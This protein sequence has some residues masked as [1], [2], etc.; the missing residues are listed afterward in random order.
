MIDSDYDWSFRHLNLQ[1]CRGIQ[2]AG[3]MGMEDAPFD[4]PRSRKHDAVEH[5]PMRVVR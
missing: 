5:R 2:T 4:A 3:Q 1:A